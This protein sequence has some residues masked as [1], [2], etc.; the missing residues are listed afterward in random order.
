MP[1][2]APAVEWQKKVDAI[3]EAQ[4][5]DLKYQSMETVKE[6]SMKVEQLEK[7]CDFLRERIE[8]LEATDMI[9]GTPFAG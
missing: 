6:L 8:A 4:K 2:H 5:D 3:N 9:P 1:I 7:T